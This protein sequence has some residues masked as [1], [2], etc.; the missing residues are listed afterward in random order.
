[1]NNERTPTSHEEVVVAGEATGRVE[2]LLIASGEVAHGFAA[3]YDR[4][5]VGLLR[6]FVH[7][8]LDGQIAADLTAET[9]A[10][11]AAKTS[12]GRVSAVA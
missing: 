2:D 10:D 9:L 11:A 6:F 8:T 1:M 7:H 12:C 5:M 3:F 4:T